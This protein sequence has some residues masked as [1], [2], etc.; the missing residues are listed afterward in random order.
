MFDESLLE[1]TGDQE[2]VNLVFAAG[3]S[4]VET[5]SDLLGRIVPRNRI[6]PLRPLN[7]MPAADSPS[8]SQ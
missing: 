3:F 7:E 4:T 6:L 5:V 1:R 2:A 8:S